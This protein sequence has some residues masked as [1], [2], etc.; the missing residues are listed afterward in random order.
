L[1][2]HL[3]GL[4][5]STSPVS[6]IQFILG[7]QKSHFSAILF[8]RTCD[9]LRYRRMKRTVNVIM[10]CPSHVKNATAVPCEMQN[11]FCLMEG[12]PPNAGG[13]AKSVLCCVTLKT[14]GYI[15]WQL[16]WNA[17]HHNKQATI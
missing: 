9:Y 5:L 11:S 4:D 7:N 1:H 2:Q 3:L 16:E 15:V 10:N 12:I 13:F 14:A 6:C 8:I 17:A